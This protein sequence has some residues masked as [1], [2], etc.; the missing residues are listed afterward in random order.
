MDKNQSRVAQEAKEAERR[1][2]EVQKKI[3]HLSEQIANPEKHFSRKNDRTQ[4]AVERFRRYF[5]LDQATH[6]EKRK[7]TRAEM[8]VQRNRAIA[9]V[10]IAFILLFFVFLR[11]CKMVFH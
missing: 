11:I 1:S 4:S 8:R 5:T 6:I 7:P 10:M 3:H 2:A 9:W